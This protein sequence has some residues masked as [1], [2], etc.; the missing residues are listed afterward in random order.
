ML[1]RALGLCTMFFGIG[2]LRKLFLSLIA[3]LFSLLGSGDGPLDREVRYPHLH[4][5]GL[6]ARIGSI[7]TI[8]HP[9]GPQ[10]DSVCPPVSVTNGAN[11]LNPMLATRLV[12]TR[13]RSLMLATTWALPKPR[14]GA[15]R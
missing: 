5:R 13:M 6:H 7:F 10:Y 11:Q 8:Q 2:V 14:L 12:G 3:L 1:R 9:Q 15:G 4:L